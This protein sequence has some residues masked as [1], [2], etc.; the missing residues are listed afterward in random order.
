MLY[1]HNIWKIKRNFVG[2]L[3]IDFVLYLNILIIAHDNV[4]VVI[5][6]FM[7]IKEESCVVPESFFQNWVGKIGIN[8]EKPKFSEAE[9]SSLTSCQ[10]KMLIERGIPVIRVKGPEFLKVFVSGPSSL[11]SVIIARDEL[12]GLADD[13]SPYGVKFLVSDRRIYGLGWFIL[14]GLHSWVVFIMVCDP[15]FFY[16]EKINSFFVQY[17]ICHL[18]TFLEIFVLILCELSSVFFIRV[19]KLLM[20]M[21]SDKAYDQLWFLVHGKFHKDLFQEILLES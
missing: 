16:S 18:D 21:H 6:C 19:L 8:G 12:K 7:D 5:L 14:L 11:K 2:S 15:N 20:L 9:G 17:Q 13:L 1:K 10:L 4:V 3:G